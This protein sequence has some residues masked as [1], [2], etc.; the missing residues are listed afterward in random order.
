MKLK[1]RG[2]TL[3]EVMIVILIVAILAS[4]AMPQYTKVVEKAKMT[5][6]RT[7][8]SAI[9]ASE[10]IYY[11]EHDNY[12][13]DVTQLALDSNA[14]TAGN[15]TYEITVATEADP[16]TGADIP[17]FTVVATRVGGKFAGEKIEMDKD[18]ILTSSTAQY[19]KLL[20]SKTIE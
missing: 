10:G 11:A 2:F 8:L 18:G 7:T 20:G 16:S 17:I 13:T 4:L 1:W 15:Y 6:A 3:I 5:E 9:R 14:L 12:T 19:S